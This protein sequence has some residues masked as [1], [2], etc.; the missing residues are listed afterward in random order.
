M[1]RTLLFPAFTLAMICLIA[2][3]WRVWEWHWAWRA[4]TAYVLCAAFLYGAG[5]AIFWGRK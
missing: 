1:T 2:G 4:V 3:D 5:V